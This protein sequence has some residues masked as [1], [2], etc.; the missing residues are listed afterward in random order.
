MEVACRNIAEYRGAVLLHSERREAR[1]R[2][3][4]LQRKVKE[5]YKGDSLDIADAGEKV[6]SPINDRLIELDINPKIP[7]IEILSEDF[8]ANVQKHTQGDPRSQSHPVK[9]HP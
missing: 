6:K 1:R 4:S 5:R 3:G 2:I 9:Q 8:I 7:P